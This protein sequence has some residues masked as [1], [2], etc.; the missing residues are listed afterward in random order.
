M[1]QQPEPTPTFNCLRC[2]ETYQPHWRDPDDSGLCRTCAAERDGR[3]EFDTHPNH[4]EHPCSYGTEQPGDPCRYCA[5]PVPTPGPCPTCWLIF[6]GMAHA[7]IKALLAAD[8][9]S[10]GVP[11]PR[12][13]GLTQ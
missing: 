1:T 6:E 13:E 12:D 9:I 8:G 5:A 2:G 4:P 11:H 10:L 3:C 7:D